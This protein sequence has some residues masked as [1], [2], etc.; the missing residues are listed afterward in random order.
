MEALTILAVGSVCLAC[1]LS[2]VNVGQ[3]VAKGEEVKLLVKPAEPVPVQPEPQEAE[4]AK[5]RFEAIMQNIDNYDGT[6]QG[7]V[8]VPWR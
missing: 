3:K 4:V 7:Q 2:G 8:D 6:E 1:F 5:S